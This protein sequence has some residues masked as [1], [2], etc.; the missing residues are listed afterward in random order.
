MKEQEN[1]YEKERTSLKEV[2]KILHMYGKEVNFTRGFMKLEQKKALQLEI[3]MK[4]ID[5]RT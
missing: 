1:E 4:K 2:K 3:N 5:Q